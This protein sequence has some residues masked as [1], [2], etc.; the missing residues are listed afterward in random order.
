MV[1]RN[2]NIRAYVFMEYNCKAAERNMS[3]FGGKYF[4]AKPI[5]IYT[6]H[7]FANNMQSHA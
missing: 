7:K 6:V 3:L 5:M 1:G 2:Q 4:C